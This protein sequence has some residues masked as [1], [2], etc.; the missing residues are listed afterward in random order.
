MSPLVRGL[1]RDIVR[2]SVATAVV[3]AMMITGVVLHEQLTSAAVVVTD[4][5]ALGAAHTCVINNDNTVWCWGSNALGQLGV[6]N[7]VVA[8]KTSLPVQAGTLPEGRVAVKIAAGASHTCVLADDGTV[9]CWGANPSG[10]VSNSVDAVLLMPTQVVLP[11]EAQSVF[12]GGENSCALLE[13]ENLMCWGLNSSGQLGIGSSDNSVN[14]TPQSVLNI[15]QDFRVVDL[16][17]GRAHICAVSTTNT[18]WCWGGTS[19]GK[20][21]VQPGAPITSPQQV[22]AISSLASKASAGEGHTCIAFVSSVSCFGDNYYGQLAFTPLTE[23]NVTPTP[24]E[25]SATVDDVVAGTH[26]TCVRLRENTPRCWGRN[27]NSQLGTGNSSTAPREIPVAVEGLDGTVVDLA[28]GGSHGCALM[29][30][31]QVRCWGHN[32]DGQLGVGDRHNRS[33][34]TAVSTLNVVPTTTTTTTSST[35]TTTTT[36]ITAPNTIPQDQP[37][38]D[39]AGTGTTIVTVVLSAVSQQKPV[40]TKLRLRRGRSVSASKIARAVSMTIPKT[41]KGKMRIS[42]T[43]GAKFCAFKNTSIRATRKGRCTVTVTMIPK[44]GKEITRKTTI[45][46]T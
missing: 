31:G 43:R 33:T 36:P 6:A 44:K 46:V 20:L 24:T 34:A 26:F 9:W 14:G 21:A 27:S 13:D 12:A 42:I 8:E 32:D 16:A 5:M 37:A 18:V 11:E 7:T 2:R 29:A 45:A 10:Q 15:P 19:S 40:I 22:S 38:I 30:S 25:L 4:R 35:T 17:I 1:A 23:I 41:S 39:V 28:L 3:L